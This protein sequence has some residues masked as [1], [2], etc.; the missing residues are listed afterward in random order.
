MPTKVKIN[1]NL[2]LS[3]CAMSTYAIERINKSDPKMER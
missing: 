2:I 1:E 3:K